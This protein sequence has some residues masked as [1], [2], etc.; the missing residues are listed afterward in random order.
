MLVVSATAGYRHAGAIAAGRRMLRAL[1]LGR[2]DLRMTFTEDVAALE[3]R[4]LAGTRAVVF[5]A[6]SGELPLSPAARAGLVA[7]VRRGGG[8]V[9]VHSAAD[10]LYGY[11]PYGRMLGAYFREHPNAR[12]VV[13]VARRHQVTAGVPRRLRVDD[14]IYEFRGDPRATGARV[15]LTVDPDGP[16]GPLPSAWCRRE[17]SGRVAYTALG[18]QPETWA[19]PW[20]RRHVADA[21]AW[22]ATPG[23]RC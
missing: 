10:T 9:G 22:A 13:S 19:S 17:G 16:A 23:G 6:T 3:P 14:E 2:P 18:H 7:F 8:F 1:D 20:F 11:P 4:A 5:L 21:V 12:G 15:L